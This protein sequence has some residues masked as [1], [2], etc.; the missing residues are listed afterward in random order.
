MSR[1][2]IRPERPGSGA[3]PVI[4]VSAAS[5]GWQY[6]GFRAYAL[7]PSDVV[8]LDSGDTETA[9]IVVTGSVTVHGQG[10]QFDGVGSRESVFA[11]RAPDSVLIPPHHRFAVQASEATE[12][13]VATAKQQGSSSWEPRLL[14]GGDVAIEDRGSGITER[15]VRQV[16]D[17]GDRAEK[18]L[19]VEVIT[20]P[21]HWSSFP[22]HKHDEDIPGVEGYL[23]EL[24]YF[25]LDPPTAWAVQRVYKRDVIDE[26]LI[27]H[28]GDLVLVP[29]GYHVVTTP[30]GVQAYYLNVMAG[31]E[32]KWSYRI[33][34]DF[35]HVMPPGGDIRGKVR[36]SNT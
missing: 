23:E 15:T 27:V 36:R 6:V 7:N 18:L 35:H 20:P 28:D 17:V 14:R 11:D 33:D 4:E 9:V 10:W 2:H 13:V 5:A 32:R 29:C 34:P 30:P 3:S 24:Y 31:H 8:A 26:T 12:V 16:L 22:P 1:I 21:G 25:H 19:L